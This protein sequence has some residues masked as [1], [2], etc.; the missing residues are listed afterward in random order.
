MTLESPVGLQ[1]AVVARSA[2]LV[3]D[4]FNQAEPLLDVFEQM[5]I[6]LIAEGSLRLESWFKGGICRHGNKL[7][8]PSRETRSCARQH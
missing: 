7:L 8:S 1:E 5:P 3:I 2:H 6:A 4:H